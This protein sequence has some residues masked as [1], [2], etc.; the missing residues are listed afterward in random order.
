MSESKKQYRTTIVLPL[1]VEKRLT[2]LC[3]LYHLSKSSV[4]SLLIDRETDKK[5]NE[6]KR[7]Q[8]KRTAGYCEA[9]D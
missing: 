4:I 3:L 5:S 6:L 8:E 1:E 9:I 2:E 7:L